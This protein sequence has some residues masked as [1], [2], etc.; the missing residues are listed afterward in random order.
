M[1]KITLLFFVFTAFLLNAQVITT[2]DFGTYTIGD[3][4]GQNGW[5]KSV[6][7]NDAYYSSPQ[8]A[9]G[10]LSY[11]GYLSSGQ[12]KWIVLNPTNGDAANSLTRISTKSTAMKLADMTSNGG[13]MY[14]SFLAKIGA[15]SVDN[16][17]RDFF[18]FESST[19][20]SMT[21]GRVIAKY[22]ST[23]NNVEIGI[24]KN[25]STPTL[26]A[27]ARN[28]SV[29]ETFLVVL[30][31]EINATASNDDPVSI[32]LNPDLSSDEATN[33]VN[34]ITATD[35]QTDYTSASNA[36]MYN[37]RQ[38]LI[39]GKIS[40]IRVGYKWVDVVPQQT[41]ALTL[42]A[43]ELKNIGSITSNG[44]T[45][46]W[47]PVAKAVGY[48]VIV[49]QG[50]TQVQS[51]YVAGQAIST[52]DV[53]GLN[54]N[55]IYTYKIQAVGNATTYLNSITSLPSSNITTTTTSL[56]KTTVSTTLTVVN[57]TIIASEIGNLK[58]YSMQGAQVL[59]ADNVKSVDSNLAKGMYIVRFSD[60][61][62]NQT[63]QKITINN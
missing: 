59:S 58:I 27:D 19:T 22:S 46:T 51:N 4:E 61:L 14:I 38:R 5:Y 32:Y 34:K 6:K 26:F 36:I 63:S 48:N 3:L 37:I 52:Y 12:S 44:F 25:S 16:S 40:G 2:E 23:T 8:I 56:N 1:R 41:G 54:A 21:R 17:A 47:V 24:S 29:D 33:A 45:A 9:T 28:V 10:T 60:A 35:V 31:Y 13:K 30:E 49:Y 18:T 39:D 50:S 43:P 20:S 7:T 57:K 11:P 42:I 15:L 62:G 53:V 55:T